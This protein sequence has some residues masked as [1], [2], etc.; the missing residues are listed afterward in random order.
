MKDYSTKISVSPREKYLKVFFLDDKNAD[1][2]KKLLEKLNEV[3]TVNV[4]LSESKSHPEKTLTVY[5]KPMVTIETL[6]EIVNKAIDG[7]NSGVVEIQTDIITEVEFH[8]IEQKIINALNEAQAMIDICVA[9]FT[10]ETL[11]KLLLK[12]KNEG[13]KIR[14][15]IDANHTNKKHGVDLTPFDFKEIKASRCGIMHN[16]FCIID[17]NIVIHGSYNWTT[18]AETKN[19]EEVSVTK[20]DVN[21]ASKYTREFNNMWEAD[22]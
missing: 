13:C 19:N 20:N 14:V 10:N 5:S 8:S 16:K 4:T 3:R 7:Y 21:M 6:M 15:L 22:I 17:N 18:N 2:V 12:K 9:W 1:G 11:Q